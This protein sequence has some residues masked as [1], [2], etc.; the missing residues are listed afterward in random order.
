MDET[1]R[2]SSQ[3]DIVLDLMTESPDNRECGYYFVD[4]S[5][6]VVYWL[7]AFNMS[8]LENW[9]QIQGIDTPSHASE[10]PASPLFDFSA[11][12]DL[13]RDVSGN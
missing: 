2:N 6:R 12:H 13:Y 11:D 3:V 8:N 1:D 10:W 5:A 9:C 4:H 7:E